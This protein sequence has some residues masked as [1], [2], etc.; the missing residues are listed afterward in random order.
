MNL[1]RQ[2]YIF[3]FNVKFCTEVYRKRTQVFLETIFMYF[4]NYK[5]SEGENI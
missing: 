4:D 5:Y 2:R 3:R 1:W